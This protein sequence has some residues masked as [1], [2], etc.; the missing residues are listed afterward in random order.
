MMD[1]RHK[2]IEEPNPEYAVEGPWMP[3]SGQTV[4]NDLPT[5]GDSDATSHPLHQ[6][7]FGSSHGFNGETSL[8]PSIWPS[9][10]ATSTQDYFSPGPISAPLND[11]P[12][13]IGP[14][15]FEYGNEMDSQFDQPNMILAQ[16]TGISQDYDYT[17]HLYQSVRPV[18]GS[19]IMASSPLAGTCPINAMQN[20]PP[21]V[22]ET[23]PPSSAF[24][25][26]YGPPRG[27]A[28]Q[29]TSE[30]TTDKRPQ[31][32]YDAQATNK[33]AATGQSQDWIPQETCCSLRSISFTGTT[34]TSLLRKWRVGLRRHA[35]RNGHDT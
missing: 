26:N 15:A 18:S 8:G 9:T 7:T 25:Y 23:C 4:V 17:Q 29:A 12:G 32:S 16:N 14:T 2:A 5:G 11:Q 13:T 3:R 1:D 24:Y 21:N 20:V 33:T 35:K 28:A 27:S 6:P 30:T 34:G 22:V 10:A 19:N 31:Q